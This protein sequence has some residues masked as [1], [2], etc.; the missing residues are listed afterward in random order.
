MTLSTDDPLM[1]HVTK[2]PLVEEYSVA[3][4]VWK[5]SSVDTCEIARNS[6]LQSGFEHRFKAHWLGNNYFIRSIDGKGQ[7][8]SNV[9]AIRL[10]F[11]YELLDKEFETI[12]DGGG[13]KATKEMYCDILSGL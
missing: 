11:R 13:V 12:S 9:P 8:K 3:A 7:L 1:I 4:Q 2:E 6:V 10:A 5:L